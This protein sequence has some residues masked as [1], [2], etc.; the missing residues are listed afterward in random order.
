MQI[1]RYLI[2]NRKGKIIKEPCNSILSYIISKMT[3]D[4]LMSEF[5]KTIDLINNESQNE[6]DT[7]NK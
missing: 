5:Y 6:N 3:K 2:L 4:Y 1:R 7:S